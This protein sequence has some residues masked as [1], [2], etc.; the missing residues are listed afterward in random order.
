MKILA[1]DTS[2]EICSAAIL[3]DEII[4]DENNLESGKTHSENL[5]P[6]L[7]EIIKRNNVDLKDID[8]FACSVGPG[9]FTGIRI[10]ISTIKSMAEV[11]NKPIASI[12]SLETLARNIENDEKINNIENREVVVSI[13]DAKNNQVYSG[14]FDKKFNKIEDYI[15]NDINYVIEKI[16]KYNNAIIVGNGAIV[17]KKL[18]QEQLD[19]PIF[20]ENNKQLAKNVGK[21]AYKKYIENELYNADTLFPIYLKKSQAEKLKKE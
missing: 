19:N 18:L 20:L 17:H 1:I 16:K 2:S 7:D 4:I 9:S 3:E 5:I 8:L 10:G 6:V 11:L 14:I 12:T 13:I 15:A 21:M